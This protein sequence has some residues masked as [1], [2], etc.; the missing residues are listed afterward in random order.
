MRNLSWQRNQQGRGYCFVRVFFWPTHEPQQPSKQIFEAH[1]EHRIKHDDEEH[2]YDEF[3]LKRHHS[4]TVHRSHYQVLKFSQNNK[5]KF[6]ILDD[7][8]F[9]IQQYEEHAEPFKI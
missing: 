6:F 5:R 4:I 7:G 9:I 3:P 1:H 8:M 2:P